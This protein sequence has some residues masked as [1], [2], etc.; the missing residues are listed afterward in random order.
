MNHPPI[1]SIF[2]PH[3]GCISNCIFCNQKTITGQR[4]APDAEEVLRAIEVCLLTMTSPG[5]VAFFGGSFTALPTSRQEMYLQCVQPY[6]KT[7][8]I[9]GIRISTRPDFID[10]QI[11]DRLAGYGVKT[12]EL[13]VQSLD[14]EVL[15]LAKRD[16]P[17]DAVKDASRLIK[18]RGF[19]LGHQLMI[20]LPLADQGSEMETVR[21]VIG[22]A[23]HLARIYPTLILRG[24]HLADLYSRGE[25]QPLGLDEAVN[26]AAMVYLELQGAGIKVIRMGLQSTPDLQSAAEVVAGPFHPAFGELVYSR[27]IRWQAS[28]LI[29]DY[30]K[31]G[32]TPAV[33]LFVNSKDI[34]RMIGAGRCQIKYLKEEYLLQKI[35]IVGMDTSPRDW[36][37][38]SNGN[39]NF[40]E[41]TLSRQEFYGLQWDC[42]AARV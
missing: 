5:E 38:I 25:Y 14:P 29:K 24:T 23:P 9:T 36:V 10:E 6:L 40:P 8:Q 28:Y 13:G 16:Y 2:I 4:S 3:L 15:K 20:G 31:R 41:Q 27:V 18:Q 39:N 33:R 37:G 21:K 11:L 17:P 32:L 42:Q 35:E 19:N 12:I 30:L 34:S 7:G 26:I 1:V 22:M